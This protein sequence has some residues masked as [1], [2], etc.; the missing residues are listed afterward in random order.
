MG[1]WWGSGGAKKSDGIVSGALILFLLSS[2]QNLPL[3]TYGN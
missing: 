3:A 2:W 1:N